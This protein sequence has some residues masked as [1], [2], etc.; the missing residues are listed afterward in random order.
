MTLHEFISTYD[1]PG[2]VVLLEGNREVRPADGPKLEAL[3][4][5]LARST[6]HMVFRSGNASGAD[7]HFAAGVVAVDRERLQVVTPY[8][9]HRKTYNEAG[10]TVDLG[11]IDM[12]AE[13]AVPYQTKKATPGNADLVDHYLGGARDRNAQKVLY[14]LRDT[15]KVTGSPAAGLAPATCGLFY[16]VSNKAT[17]GTAHTMRVCEQLGVPAYDQ[18]V[19]MGWV[20]SDG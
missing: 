5:L 18:R 2:A 3:A 14:L 12:A 8:S 10:T 11:M 4:T 19:W 6:K 20:R 15:L 13:P 17:S 9:G 1:K 7:A 16:H